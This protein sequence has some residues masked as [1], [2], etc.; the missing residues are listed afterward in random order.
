MKEISK[1]DK[2][3]EK[4]SANGQFLHQNR[5]VSL[6]V[7]PPMGAEKE[8]PT[9]TEQAASSSLDTAEP[10]PL[11]PAPWAPWELWTRFSKKDGWMTRAMQA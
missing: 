9:P 5:L 1:H 11:P 10:T 3:G 4:T 6:L 7:S 2:N 8:A